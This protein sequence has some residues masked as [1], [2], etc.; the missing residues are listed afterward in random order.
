MGFRREVK[1]GDDAWVVGEGW[2]WITWALG[3]RKPPIYFDQ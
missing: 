1:A 2:S 3:I